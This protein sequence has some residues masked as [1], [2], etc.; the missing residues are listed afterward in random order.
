MGYIIFIFGSQYPITK[1][2][3]VPNIQQLDTILA[4]IN[5]SKFGGAV[6]SDGPGGLLYTPISV[7]PEDEVNRLIE[8][9]LQARELLIAF[10]NTDENSSKNS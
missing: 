8:W 2:T 1:E 3:L 10:G 7:V 5:D 4:K 9:A 6:S